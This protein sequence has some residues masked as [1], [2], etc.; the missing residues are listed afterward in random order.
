METAPEKQVEEFRL[1][2]TQFS[3]VRLRDT[4][5]AVG[6]WLTRPAEKRLQALELLRG[7]FYG[8]ASTSERLQRVLEVVELKR[9]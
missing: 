2:R 1:G 3:V 9:S 7:T 8:E 4:D 5:D 6:Y